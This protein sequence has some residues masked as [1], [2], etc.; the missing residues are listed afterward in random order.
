MIRRRAF[1]P[2]V[3]ILAAAPAA[4][5]LP[6]GWA[7]TGAP[8]GGTVTEVAVSAGRAWAATQSSGLFRSA[9]GG[10]SWARIEEAPVDRASG[11]RID[12]DW[13]RGTILAVAADPQDPDTAYV[14]IPAAVL[15]TSDGGQTWRPTGLTGGISTI[16]ISPA[17][18]RV[19]YLADHRRIWRSA[20]RGATWRLGRP[21]PN[22]DFLD[23]FA[24]DPHDPLTVFV[25]SGS[26]L[27]RSTDGGR[28]WTA[29]QGLF[30]FDEIKKVAVDP[31]DPNLV[32]AGSR[33]GKIWRSA[34]RGLNWTQVADFGENFQTTDL[35]F[36][37]ATPGALLIAGSDFPSFEPTN[38]TSG[39]LLRS[40]DGGHTWTPVLAT[41]VIHDL[42]FDPARPGQALLATDAFGVLRSADSAATWAP[43]NTGL[44]AAVIFQITPAPQTPGTLYTVV[45]AYR[46]ESV[47]P[48]SLGI[49]KSTDGAATW[50]PANQGLPTHGGL[51][52][53]I[54]DLAADFTRP[55][56]LY[57]ATSDG[58]FKTTDGAATWFRADAGSQV[59]SPYDV[60]L[61]PHDPDVVYTVGVRSDGRTFAVARSANGG[62]NWVR[63]FGVPAI[64]PIQSVVVDLWS[65]ATVFVSS[66]AGFYRSQDDGV[67][68]TRVS[69]PQ[70]PFSRLVS[71]L[72]PGQLAGLGGTGFDLLVSPD[73][74]ATWSPVTLP[75]GS[76]F[77]NTVYDLSR[78]SLTEREASL[79]AASRFGVAVL[80][81]G[82]TAWAPVG[83]LFWAVSAAGDPTIPGRVYA[84]ARDG[85]ILVF[86]N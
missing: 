42:D 43:S 47:H 68:W 49:W 46:T 75:G 77:E 32:Y 19:V 65:P 36:D 80:V 29:G 45:R 66:T 52:A 59:A 21:L 41:E 25:T 14:S 37:P 61:D 84:G 85:R 4:A 67:T 6:E 57:A 34:D 5:A 38:A 20:N 39:K 2:L 44:N 48:V 27:F 31:G 73:E 81:P 28:T 3:A 70:N 35:E 74:G 86:E 55:G 15:K 22:F 83:G 69:P 63:R 18:P 50:A 12:P 26:S 23:T 30:P 9:D 13:Q 33:F 8:G 82:T 7:S 58:L 24:L 62:A 60:A 16:G 10:Q 40:L 78:S 1:L 53:E 71:G 51:L 79:Y 76:R 72:A 11:F 56:V 64:T 54:R 17:D